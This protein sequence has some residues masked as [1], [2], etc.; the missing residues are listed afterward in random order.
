MP[1]A[2]PPSPVPATGACARKPAAPVL[3][4]CA[5]GGKPGL[6]GECEQCRAK[7]PGLQRSAVSAGPALAPSSVHRVLASPGR[8]LDAETRAFMEPRV[9][10]SFADVRVHADGQAAD[11][12]RAVG[13]YAYTVGRHVVFGAGEYAPETHAGRRLIAHELAHVCQQA[14]APD[15]GVQMAEAPVQPLEGGGFRLAVAP[16]GSEDEALEREAVTLA[17]AVVG[18][19]EAAPDPRVQSLSAALGRGVQRARYPLPTPVPM[20]GRTVTHIDVEPPRWRDLVPCTPPGLP[21]WRINIV[22]REVGPTTTGRGRIVFNLHVGYFTDPATGRFCGVIHDSAG[23]LPGAN[24]RIQCLPTLRD[25][26]EWILDALKTL[27]EA[28]G[29]VLLIILLILIGRGLLRPGPAPG[30]MPSPVL[31]QGGEG[32]SPEPAGAAGE[33]TA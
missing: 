5:C 32:A 7:R 11:S 28:I 2:A 23:C 26:V 24:C 12:A 25:V 19:T 33:E 18:R 31:A 21:V 30:P 14:R 13:A 3:R 1:A 27:L 4:R 8:P 10:H 17:E 6:D 9:G 20:C 22:G 15:P 29:I 16:S